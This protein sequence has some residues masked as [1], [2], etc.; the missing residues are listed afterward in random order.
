[1]PDTRRPR[2]ATTR[3]Y[4]EPREIQRL[5]TAALA[6]GRHAHR[7]FTLIL[8]AYRHGLKVG[9][10]TGLRWSKVDF[11][12]KLLR[13][14]RLRKDV[15]ST[16]PLLSDELKALRRL[17]RDYPAGAWLFVNSR[18][19]QLTERSVNRII[20]DAG[21]AAR[22]KFTVSPRTLRRSCGRNLALA[23]HD[24][25]AVQRFLRLEDLTQIIRYLEL[26]KNPFRDFWAS[27]SKR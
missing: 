3:D 19:E 22:L 7:N 20:T 27:A 12:R 9:E 13:F 18:G 15:P 26:P 4:L 21:L 25:H 17:R 16:H 1:M 11:E 23:G 24:L 10:L 2:A 5:L 6:G 8:L 14:A